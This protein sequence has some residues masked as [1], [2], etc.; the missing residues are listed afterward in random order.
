LYRFA[1]ISSTINSFLGLMGTTHCT[2]FYTLTKIAV[3]VKNLLDQELTIT[4]Y[5]IVLY[6]ET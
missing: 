1:K 6:S 4:I 3:G 5:N 2:R